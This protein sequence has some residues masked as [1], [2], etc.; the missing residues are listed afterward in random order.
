[1]VNY[2]PRWLVLNT[3]L[4]GSHDHPFSLTA[5]T[6]KFFVL[7]HFVFNLPQKI[8][9]KGTWGRSRWQRLQ[10]WKKSRRAG[11][12]RRA[13][14][15]P[16]ICLICL[17]DI[18]VLT[19]GQLLVLANSIKISSINP[20]LGSRALVSKNSSFVVIFFILLFVP[21]YTSFLNYHYEMVLLRTLRFD[22]APLPPNDYWRVESFA[23][24]LEIRPRFFR[25]PVSI[26]CGF[27]FS[28]YRYPLNEKAPRTCWG[29]GLRRGL[30]LLEI[31]STL[32]LSL[33]LS[34][35]ANGLA[36]DNQK[37]TLRWLW[38]GWPSNTVSEEY[39]SNHTGCEGR[40]V[41]IK[42]MVLS[43]PAAHALIVLH[44]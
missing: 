33:F 17:E 42:E 38:Q 11:V 31:P 43:T 41:G 24:T 18:L 27:Y 35:G 14:L 25:F 1:M 2:C 44:S 40:D 34:R 13:S 26:A 21:L 37:I 16:I 20:A 5:R 19:N 10:S 12:L 32:K 7:D 30:S 28:S 23:W 4:V 22:T 36:V 9:P 3:S 39:D 8:F 6:L 15:T 29:W